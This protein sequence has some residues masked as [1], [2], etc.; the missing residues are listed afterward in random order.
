MGAPFDDEDQQADLRLT[1]IGIGKV[2]AEAQVA[3][4]LF[5]AHYL[6]SRNILGFHDPLT[7]IAK[8]RL[9]YLVTGW[10]SKTD[11]DPLWSATEKPETRPTDFKDWPNSENG[12]ATPR[13]PTAAA[14]ILCHVVSRVGM[15]QPDK[16]YLIRNCF[17]HRGRARS[18]WDRQTPAE[19]LSALVQ[20]GEL[21]QDL[22]ALVADS[23]LVSGS[24][25][26]KLRS[27]LHSHRFDADHGPVCA[28]PEIR[29]ADS[30]ASGTAGSANA[31]RFAEELANRLDRLNGRQA[32]C[33]SDADT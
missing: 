26:A 22:L 12:R 3:A 17:R 31:Y 30:T 10:F 23:L 11:D 19:A 14:Q 25:I 29:A 33:D 21:E 6:A 13:R 5:S 1:A 15:D 27:D 32:A 16:G 8:A 4:P 2:D 7:D 28:Q 9:G 18:G 24:A 20:D